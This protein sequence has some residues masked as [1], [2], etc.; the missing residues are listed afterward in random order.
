MSFDP[1]QFHFDLAD[2]LKADAWF[3]DL[4]IETELPR[5]V[6]AG[7]VLENGID[8]VFAAVEG[9]GAAVLVLLPEL[10]S[11]RPNIPGPYFDQVELY[12]LALTSELLNASAGG[13]KLRCFQIARR[14]AQNWHHFTP[15]NAAGTLAVA[16]VAPERFGGLTRE[17][18]DAIRA[19][20]L[21]AVGVQ[22]KTGVGF[23]TVTK[24][25]WPTI[26]QGETTI[27]LTPGADGGTVWYTTDGT[28][29]WDGNAAATQYS[30][31]FAKPDAGTLI[32]AAAYKTDC[33]GS[34]VREHT[35]TA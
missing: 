11:T 29:P 12:G 10:T 17:M 6:E 30:A 26:A 23:A 2:H 4:V 1:V 16:V 3:D 7:A 25:I 35:V 33:L 27:T 32:R 28:F 9:N 18:L 34:D 8:K 20:G 24:T 19:Q 5:T 31:P 21:A 22:V 15:N 14:M 13:A